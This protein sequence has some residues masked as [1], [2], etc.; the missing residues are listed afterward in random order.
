[1]FTEHIDILGGRE[2]YILSAM[3]K[4]RIEAAGGM[5]FSNMP[6][7]IFFMSKQEMIVAEKTHAL[8]HNVGSLYRS[9]LNTDSSSCLWEIMESFFPVDFLKGL[10]YNNIG[11]VITAEE[12]L[13]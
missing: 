8:S 2:K 13:F 6:H 1:M 9:L 12:L 7:C 5:Q 4:M 10:I 3:Q 11:Y